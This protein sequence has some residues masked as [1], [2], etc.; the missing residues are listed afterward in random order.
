MVREFRVLDEGN[1]LIVVVG[2]KWTT[3]RLMAEKAVDLAIKNY[4]LVAENRCFTSKITILGSRKY[5]RDLHY[6]I[7]STCT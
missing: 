6:V 7:A 4:K 5:S 2:G 3:F 1:G